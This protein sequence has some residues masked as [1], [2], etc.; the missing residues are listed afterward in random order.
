MKERSDVMKK[1]ITKVK[2]FFGLDTEFEETF[3]ESTQNPVEQVPN[4]E[5][6]PKQKRAHLQSVPQPVQE[7]P[8]QQAAPRK[9]KEFRFPLI[10]DEEKESITKDDLVQNRS[11][12][13]EKKS[14][15]FEDHNESSTLHL[16]KHLSSNSQVY[17][18]E[19]S[20]I[21]DL[22]EKR[23][24]SHGVTNVVR[25]QRDT[26]PARKT[27]NVTRDEAVFLTDKPARQDV[28]EK[29]ENPAFINPLENKKRFV[30]THVPSPVHGFKEPKPIKELLKDEF[31]AKLT[32]PV[33]FQAEEV[34]P[35]D[36]KQMVHNRDDAYNEQVEPFVYSESTNKQAQNNQIV[37]QEVAVTSIEEEQLV[38]QEYPLQDATESKSAPVEQVTAKQDTNKLDD[39]QL[40]NLTIENST[41]HI[42][43]IHV[44]PAQTVIVKEQ[45]VTTDE[46]QV[47]APV[48]SQAA[49]QQQNISGEISVENEPVQKTSGSKIPFNVLML[50]SDKNKMKGNPFQQ[51]KSGVPATITEKVELRREAQQQADDT[52]IPAMGSEEEKSEP[53]EDRQEQLL[54]ESTYNNQIQVT[55]QAEFH[56]AASSDEASKHI[57]QSAVAVLERESELAEE[58]LIPHAST[59]QQVIDL[60]QAAEAEESTSVFI[61]DVQYSKQVTETVDD[62]EHQVSMQP[63]Q[64]NEQQQ[65]RMQLEQQEFEQSQQ[66]QAMQA[67][68]KQVDMQSKVVQGQPLDSYSDPQL[69]STNTTS[70][71]KSGMHE[72]SATTMLSTEEVEEVEVPPVAKPV[73]PYQKPSLDILVPP[74][75]KTE[76]WAWM[77]E[78]ADY[79]IAALASHQINAQIESI[80]QGPAVTQFEI[81][82]AA[83]T[84]VSK[85][86]NLSD[87]IKLALAAKDI[88]IDAPI[89]GKRTIGIEI[90]NRISRAVRLSEVTDSEVFQN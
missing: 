47:E 35:A 66:P 51:I 49:P 5:E 2:R 71:V 24:R 88:R 21:R 30:P 54:T 50:S 40:Q 43:Q 60:L 14:A 77:D 23:N 45:I 38:Q 55:E 6:V 27:R 52:H 22:L 86:R 42:G 57:S 90:P 74:E 65:V 8:V 53:L 46:Q 59:P 19:V 3:E 26:A 13:V 64:Q 11:E 81:T 28:V 44:E 39:L 18:V 1:V 82:V 63:E 89:P 79:L 87:D 78:Q 61:S 31:D 41:V 15:V 36:S 75:E 29:N 17:D 69:A 10:K 56:T 85:V 76:D 67:E 20:G 83:G 48:T 32:I 73:K 9:Q 80:V 12:R 7:K 68:Q 58:Q 4:N 72:Q 25:L 70:E 84:K 37:E 16:P 34:V 33:V 62:Q